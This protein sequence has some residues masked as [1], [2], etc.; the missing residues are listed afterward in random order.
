[1]ANAPGDGR[2]GAYITPVAR[3]TETLRE[4]GLKP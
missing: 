4:Q 1:M 3:E 2:N